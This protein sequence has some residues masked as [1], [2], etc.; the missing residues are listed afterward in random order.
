MVI[1]SDAVLHGAPG[2]S[3]YAAANAF[4]DSLI[5]YRRVRGLAALSIAFGPWDG[6]GM[7]LRFGIADHFA[8]RGIGLLS[9]SEALGACERALSSGIT[10][11]SV[12]KLCRPLT[13][14][15]ASAAQTQHTAELSAIQRAIE[16]GA[17]LDQQR[18]MRTYLQKRGAELLRLDVLPPI[19]KGFFTLGIDSLLAITFVDELRRTLGLSLAATLLIDQ[20]NIKQLTEFLLAQLKEKSV[21]SQNSVAEIKV[22]GIR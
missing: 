11:A 13:V 12:R 4:V 20:P 17:T 22:E 8:N 5:Q 18:Q 3:G 10:W 9:T 2:Q 1:S 21:S 16:G 19:E 6:P 14:Q 7:S 15:R